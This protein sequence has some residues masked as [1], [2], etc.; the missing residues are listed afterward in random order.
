MNLPSDEVLIDHLISLQVCCER[1]TRL[2]NG[3]TSEDFLASEVLQLALAMAVAQ[4]GEVSGRLLRKW[5][6]FCSEHP[7]LELGRSNSMRHRL[8]HGYDQIDMPTLWD[9][10]QV[11]VPVMLEAVGK[12]LSTGNGREP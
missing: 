2:T 5:P 11:S 7:E 8:V 10:V 6:I 1:A 4:I 3:V 9:T 12:L